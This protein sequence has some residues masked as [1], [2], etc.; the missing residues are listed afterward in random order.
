MS[1]A[2]AFHPL[3]QLAAA[4]QRVAPWYDI[5]KFISHDCFGQFLVVLLKSRLFVS[6]DSHLSK[7]VGGERVCVLCMFIPV[8]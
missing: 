8:V 6:F 3:A 5:L 7:S 1:L 2:I 4:L